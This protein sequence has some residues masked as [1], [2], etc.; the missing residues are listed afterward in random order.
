MAKS[1]KVLIAPSGQVTIDA[2][3]FAGPEC[4][5]ATQFLEEALGTVKTRKRKAEYH[6]AANRMQQRIGE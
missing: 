1:I 4:E 3:G 6:R 5:K 2:Q